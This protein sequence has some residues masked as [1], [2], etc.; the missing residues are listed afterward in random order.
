MHNNLPKFFLFI[1]SF[2]EEYIRK[3]DKRI[4]IIYRNYSAKTDIKIIK[5][6]KNFCRKDKRKF[7]LSNNISLAISLNLDGLYLPAF[8]QELNIKKFNTKKKFLIIGSAHSV[9]EMRIKERQGV[10]IIFLAPLFKTSK[11]SNFLDVVKFNLLTFKT[12]RKVVALGGINK[13]NIRKL[14][15]IDLHG[16]A[17]ITYFENNGKVNF[18]KNEYKK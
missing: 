7:F 1:N 12:N 8:N 2:K 15:M 17:G 13:K 4:A 3:L 10:Q 6:I 11:N 5:K 18:F 14:K 16:F 9:K